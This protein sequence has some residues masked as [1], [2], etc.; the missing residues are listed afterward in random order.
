MAIKMEA[1]P[2]EPTW[3]D[4]ITVRAFDRQRDAHALVHA[5]REAFNDHWGHVERPYEE[6]YEEWVT[7]MDEDPSFDPSL[8]FMA[9]DGEEIVGFSNCYDVTGEG[10]DVA[11]VEE[12]GV[13]RP[14]RRRG[15]ALALLQHSFGELYRR[16]QKTVTLWVDVESLTGATQLYEK[17]GMRVRHRSDHYEKMLRPG[18]DIRTG[19]V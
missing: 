10:I 11:A 7:R 1:P 5:I 8:W 9:V 12:L 4:G 19:S 15:I 13:R 14:W 6:V 3:P 16:G 17:A 18:K 2:S